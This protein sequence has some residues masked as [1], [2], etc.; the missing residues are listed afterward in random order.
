MNSSVATIQ[1][2]QFINL[3]PLEINPLMSQC[4]IKVLYL[5]ENRNGT[6]ITK[7]VATEMS[8]TLRGCPIVGYYKQEEGDFRDHGHRVVIEEDEIKFECLTIPY[9][10]VAPNADVWFQEFEDTNEF[11][12]QTKRE[13][14]MTTGYLWTGQFEEC[15]SVV[16]GEGKPQ[17]MELDK[18]SVQGHWSVNNKGMDFFIIND[19]T[20]SKLCILGDDVEP[21]FEGANITPPDISTSFTKVDNTF[22]HTLYTMM[23]ELKA[24]LEGG[25][26]MEEERQEVLQEEVSEPITEATIATETEMEAVEEITSTEEEAATVEYEE[27]AEQTVSEEESSPVAEEA[28]PAVD[29]EAQYNQLQSEFSAQAEKIATLEATISA[30]TTERDALAAFKLEVDN[31]KK[32]EMIENFYMLSEEDKK[33]VLEHKAEYSLEE[34]EEKLSV[35]CFR[36]KVNFGL[37]NKSSFN[38]KIEEIP[39]ATYTVQNDY[40]SIPAWVQAVKE[41]SK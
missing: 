2:P 35:I 39:V 34:I 9:G 31:A 27:A 18:D 23:Q 28:V 33:D 6:Y 38:N 16:E 41:N 1:S 36:K 10:F 19:A 11:G 8:K 29:F 21:C 37:E 3:S 7:E 15:K 30:L 5:G 40:S 20:F 14:L 4:N 12:E 22:K 24:A 25:Q 26:Q 13:Y 32:D 17:S